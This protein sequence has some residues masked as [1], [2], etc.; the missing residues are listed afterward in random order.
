MSKSQ[1]PYQTQTYDCLEI[2]K[3]PCNNDPQYQQLLTTITARF[4]DNDTPPII[5][6]YWE[7]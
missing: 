1:F 5:E 7:V 3:N 6:E 2:I 4:Q